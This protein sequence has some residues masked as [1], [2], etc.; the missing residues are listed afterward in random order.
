MKK[1]FKKIHLWLSV[2]LGLVIVIICFSGAMLVFEQEITEVAQ[3]DMVYVEKVGDK[4][5]PVSEIA[6]KV[7]SI[8]PDSIRVT[9]VVIS[10]DPERSCKVNISKPKKAFVYVDQYTG[11]IKGKNERLGFFKVMFRLHRWLMDSKPE[12]GGIYWGK[13]IVGV[14]TL[15]F[16]IIL[17]TGFV[18]WIPKSRKALKN[19]L[20]VCAT[21]G[22][23]RLWYDLHVA[24]GFY[25]LLLLLAMAL[26]GLTWSFSWYRTGF[27]RTFGIEIPSKS[28]PLAEVKSESDKRG[29][30]GHGERKEKNDPFASWT[31]ALDNVMKTESDYSRITVS[32]G[33]VSV[34]RDTFG[35][36]RAVDTYRFDK[37]T[38][39]ITEKQPY[40]DA[41]AAT[42]MRGWIYSVHVGNWGGMLTRILTFL[43]ALLGASLPLTGYYLW[44]RRLY[45]KRNPVKTSVSQIRN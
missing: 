20:A 16:V 35:N 7:A 26:T 37:R 27:Y 39:E 13:M 6:T 18:I 38:G 30:G 29:K 23:K 33:R 2:P 15:V 41:D 5:L 42:K 43:A 25:A 10:S 21:K 24:G 3:R 44:I 32:D 34:S 19:R 1:V 11:E 12:D 45:R 36:Q 22:W 14:S 17:I 4:A 31:V 9:G 8:L 28:V 40:A